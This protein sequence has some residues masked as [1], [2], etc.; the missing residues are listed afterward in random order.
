MSE[1]WQDRSSI[2]SSSGVSPAIAH[3]WAQ[4]YHVSTCLFNVVI[5]VKF[6]GNQYKSTDSRCSIIFSNIGH[7]D[8]PA[9]F[10]KKR[11]LNL[12]GMQGCICFLCQKWNYLTCPSLFWKMATVIHIKMW[13]ANS[14]TSSH[15]SIPIRITRPCDFQENVAPTLNHWGAG[16]LANVSS[17]SL[18]SFAGTWH[19]NS[20]EQ[21][22]WG[23]GQ[24]GGKTERTC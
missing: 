23:F 13:S 8:N 22:R 18:Q 9:P 15:P 17:E 6:G 16:S 5:L 11:H 3:H 19:E 2:S 14:A 20:W 12:I 10:A 7:F 4:R 1:R 24:W 21:C